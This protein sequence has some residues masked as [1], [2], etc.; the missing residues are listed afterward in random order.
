MRKEASQK[1][2]PLLSKVAPVYRLVE[3]SLEPDWVLKRGRK[4]MIKV[5]IPIPLRKLTGGQAVVEASGEDVAALIYVLDQKYSGL[6]ER[7]YDERGSLRRFVNIYVNEEDICF[8]RGINTAVN[9]GDEV[10]IVPAIAGGGGLRI[11]WLSETPPKSRFFT[12]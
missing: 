9:I 7:L 10:S 11:P 1:I 6:K 12:A 3:V 5:R 4:K 2:N 8:L